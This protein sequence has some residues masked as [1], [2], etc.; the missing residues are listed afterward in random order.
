MI[1]GLVDRQWAQHHYGRWYRE[2]FQANIA[3]EH[4]SLSDNKIEQLLQEA[5]TGREDDDYKP[6]EAIPI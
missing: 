4:L 2:N 3:R 1:S 5:E 6:E